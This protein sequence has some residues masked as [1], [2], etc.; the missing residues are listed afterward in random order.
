MKAL[1]ILM[2][3]LVTACGP[4]QVE[5]ETGPQQANNMSLTVSNS[6]NQAVNV[7]VVSGGNP[8]FVGQVSGNSTQTLSV[9]GV[10]SGAVV[11]LQAR[12]TDGTKTYTKDNVTMSGAY[13]WPVP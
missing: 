12:T 10:A 11:S 8:I 13:S 3:A 4:R 2:L 6:A 9:S 1:A 5:V 7:Y